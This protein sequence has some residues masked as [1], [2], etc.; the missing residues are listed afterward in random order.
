[1]ESPKQCANQL[2]TF[3]ELPI[4]PV[5]VS[6]SNSVPP[7][8][9]E[10]D[11][12]VPAGCSFWHQAVDRC[13]AT[14]AKDRKHCSI[15]VHTHNLSGA[16]VSQQVELGDSLKAMM[17]LDYVREQEVAAIPTMQRPYSHVIYCPLD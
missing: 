2:R 9:S 1:M 11:D 12:V 17:G 5:A 16:P 10:F 14:S 3:L 8:V 13:F 7:G 6:F 4:T 15:G